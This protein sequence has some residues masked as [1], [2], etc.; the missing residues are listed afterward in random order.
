MST[1]FV[2]GILGDRCWFAT[3]FGQTVGFCCFVCGETEGLDPFSAEDIAKRGF[4][5]QSFTQIGFWQQKEEVTTSTRDMSTEGLELDPPQSD[6]G[7]SNLRI[8]NHQQTRDSGTCPKFHIPNKRPDLLGWDHPR[9]VG[10]SPTTHR[11][12]KKTSRSLLKGLPLRG[13][14]TRHVQH[15]EIR[16]RRQQPEG[17]GEVL[18]CRSTQDGG[19]VG[20]GDVHPHRAPLMA[21]HLVQG[22]G[23]RSA[24]CYPCESPMIV[25]WSWWIRVN[26]SCS[27]A[28]GSKKLPSYGGFW[29]QIYRQMRSR[30]WT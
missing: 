25:P 1:D 20:L 3:C 10:F 27:I 8:F 21:L 29:D 26:S 30:M 15:H 4:E 13:V 7:P 22:M 16:Q 5:R 6:L 19:V 2:W 14:G 12:E 28:R 17:R 9:S 18:H 24:W 11:L 23:V